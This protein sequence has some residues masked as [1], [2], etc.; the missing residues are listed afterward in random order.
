VTQSHGSKAPKAMI[1]GLPK[2]PSNAF[3]QL[4]TR[5]FLFLEV[6]RGALEKMFIFQRS[7]SVNELTS[8]GA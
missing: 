7:S 6:H 5:R 8:R 3:I 4:G 1:A 2:V